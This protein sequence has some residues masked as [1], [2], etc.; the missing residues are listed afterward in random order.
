VGDC[1][2]FAGMQN[3]LHNMTPK[4]I[5]GERREI[6]GHRY[7][8]FLFVGQLQLSRKRGWCQGKQQ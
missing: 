5:V 6:Q 1:W 7:Q 4:K 3:A 8:F 2:A